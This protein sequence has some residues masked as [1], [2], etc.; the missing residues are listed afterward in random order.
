MCGD[1]LAFWTWFAHSGYTLNKWVGAKR[2]PLADP[3][4]LIEMLRPHPIESRDAPA[5][6][7]IYESPLMEVERNCGRLLVGGFSA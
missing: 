7:T 5:F 6:A 3:V 1:L 4:A 2:R